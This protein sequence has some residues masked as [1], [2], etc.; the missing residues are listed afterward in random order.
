MKFNIN[1]PEDFTGRS[2]SVSDIV[3]VIRKSGTRYY[4]CDIFGWEDI[5][6]TV[7]PVVKSIYRVLVHDAE[8]QASFCEELSKYGFH[9]MS[10][11][12]AE[13]IPKCLKLTGNLGQVMVLYLSE[14]KIGFHPVEVYKNDSKSRAKILN[15]CVS[16]EKA[17][18]II[19][20]ELL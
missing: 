11:Q 14:K 9:W 15:S 12:S 19:K 17:R 16:T 2:L 3:A 4:Y 7:S 20:E 13:Q 8:E 5:S 18:C 1:H 6:D 10:G